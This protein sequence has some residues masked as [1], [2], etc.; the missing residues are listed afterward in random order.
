VAKWKKLRGLY[1]LWAAWVLAALACNYPGLA[2]HETALSA[3]ALRQT[4]AAKAT[5]ALP[6]WTSAA[7]VSLGATAAPL[8]G[9]HTATPPGFSTATP[10]PLLEDP[11]RV[12]YFAQPGDT[13]A[14]LAGRFGVEPEL[15]LSSQ[16]IPTSAFIPTGQELRIP[17]LLEETPYPSAILPDSA[18]VNSPSAAGFDLEGYVR[19]S[20]GYLSSY[21]EKVGD[22]T[23]SG[24]QVVQLVA[25][26]SSVHPKLLLAMLEFQTGWVNGQPRDATAARY[27]LGFHV[28]GW[29]GLY[30]ELVIA[31]THL[32]IGYYGWRAGTFTQLSYRDEGGDRLAPGLN[33]GSI[34]VQSVFARLY[35]RADWAQ[36][37]Y[38][39]QGFASRY[40]QMFGDPWAAAAQ[41]EPLFPAGAAQPE[42]VL[43]FAPGE[44]WSLTGGPH[45]SWKTGS[46]RGA[47]DLAPVTG[48]K[49]CAVSRAWVTAPADGVVTRSNRNV[50]ALDLDGDGYEQTGWVI[51]FLHIAELEHIPAGTP[52]RMDDPLGHPSCEGGN[53]TGTHVHIARKYNGEWLTADGPLPFVLSGW[54]VY[55]GE[56]NYQGELR[57]GSQVVVASPVGPRT[58]IVTR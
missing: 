41:V 17:K 56:K 34:A 57:Q 23:L 1:L 32:N 13:L 42:L 21:Q 20:G 27:P 14:S 52:V 36:A 16:P 33:P 29:S 7:P 35:D 24:A 44:R 46:P 10:G 51:V 25:D 40:A 6:T 18:V 9:L 22:Q 39:P 30:K 11:N 48:E 50:V 26:E 45:L 3:E 12:R 43:P 37:I 5:R 38:G 31:A 47:V 54:Q 53:A 28:S 2:I 4:L 55:A 8:A 58:S 15:I 49:T 19:Q